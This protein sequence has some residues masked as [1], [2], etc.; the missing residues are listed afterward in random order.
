MRPFLYF[1]TGEKTM[2]F[3]TELTIRPNEHREEEKV[4]LFDADAT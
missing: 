4:H 3:L 1:W 2:N